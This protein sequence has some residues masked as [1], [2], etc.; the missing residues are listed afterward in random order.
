MAQDE[1]PAAVAP[2]EQPVPEPKKDPIGLK[3]RGDES[4]YIEGQPQRDLAV[5]EVL[6]R[7]PA[8]IRHMTS[9]ATPVYEWTKAGSAAWESG[10]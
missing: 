10:R 1:T 7:E 9:G 5:S 6:E 3:Y 4:R 2:Q 8:M